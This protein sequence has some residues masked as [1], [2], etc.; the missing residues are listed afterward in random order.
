MF[1]LLAGR[2]CSSLYC[3]PGHPQAITDDDFLIPYNG[4]S[5]HTPDL[6]APLA[7]AQA[8]ARMIEKHLKLDDNCVDAA[9]SATPQTMAALCRLTK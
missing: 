3:P 7:F 6:M 9:F 4:F 5:D 8:G 1:H 2:E